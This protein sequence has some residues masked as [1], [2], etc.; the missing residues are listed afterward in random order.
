MST[1]SLVVAVRWHSDHVSVHHLYAVSDDFALWVC[2]F[3]TYARAIGIL[4]QG[5][6]DALLSLLENAAFWTF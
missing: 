5:L 4:K 1:I 6:S 3:E 2:H